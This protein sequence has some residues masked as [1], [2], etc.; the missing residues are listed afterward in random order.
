MDALWF[1]M[2]QDARWAGFQR[3]QVACESCHVARCMSHV[4]RHTSLVT[5]GLAW[6]PITNRSVLGLVFL[7]QQPVVITDIAGACAPQ[8]LNAKPE[9]LLPQGLTLP[10]WHL[11][12]TSDSLV[13]P[14]QPALHAAP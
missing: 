2:I 10:H 11:Q 7:T 4:T 13:L 3:L 14:P 9:R 6:F 5:G 12:P 8:P 1:A